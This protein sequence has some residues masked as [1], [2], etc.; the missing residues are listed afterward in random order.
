MMELAH[1][2]QQYEIVPDRFGDSREIHA[3]IG[4]S[5][6]VGDGGRRR[7]EPKPTTERNCYG[8]GKDRYLL[9]WMQSE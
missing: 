5:S 6:L 2:T 1:K 8:G 4:D 9:T 3:N 7:T